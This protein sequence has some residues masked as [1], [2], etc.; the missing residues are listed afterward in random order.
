MSPRTGQ[1]ALADAH[2]HLFRDGHHARYGRG[3]AEGVDDLAR[4]EALRREHG[5]DLGLVVGYEGSAEFAG[6]NDHLAEWTRSHEWMTPLWYLPCAQA[7][8]EAALRDVWER[9]FVGL[10]LYVTSPREASE[11]ADCPQH[12]TASLRQHQ[13]VVS[14][15][16]GLDCVGGLMPFLSALEGCVVLFSHLG[17]PGPHASHPSQVAAARR[18]RPLLGAAKLPH[19]GVK[20]SALYAISQPSH[21]YPHPQA[22]P[23][24]ELLAE[25]FGSQRL[26]WGSDYSPC[27]EHVSFA[28]TIDAVAAYPWSPTERQA[29]LGGNLR[30]ALRG[31]APSQA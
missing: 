25:A 19:V 5:I 29:V 1:D 3:W 10:S 30:A 7:P 22:L 2:L 12:V 17:L 8:A 27:L 11:I 24:V 15:N 18:L 6:N 26:Y 4:Y 13:A 16:A 20:L 28:Q 9:G 14:I 31:L 21:D 23:F